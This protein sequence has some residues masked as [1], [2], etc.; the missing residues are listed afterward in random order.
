MCRINPRAKITEMLWV[1]YLLNK[2]FTPL[3]QSTPQKK[4]ILKIELITLSKPL[5]KAVSL[6]MQPVK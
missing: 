2:I 1:K 5:I 4:G 6:S 3:I